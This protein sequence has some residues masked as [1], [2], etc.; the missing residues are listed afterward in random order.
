LELGCGRGLHWCR[1]QPHSTLQRIRNIPAGEWI[2]LAI[3]LQKLRN[4]DDWKWNSGFTVSV[5]I[6][7]AAHVWYGAIRIPYSAID[8]RPA[9]AGNLLRINFFRSQGPSSAR[10]QIAWQAPMSE[11]SHVPEQ[12]GLLKLV[13]RE[14]KG[15]ILNLH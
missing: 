1:L 8:N 2:D 10:R 14:E 6:D 7:E 11:S 13:K 3:D 9:M 12:F 5:R 15:A 4:E